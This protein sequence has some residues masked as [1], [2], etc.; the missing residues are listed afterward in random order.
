[1]TRIKNISPQHQQLLINVFLILLILI[2]YVQVGT[3]DFIDYDDGLY[4]TENSHVRKGLTID[5]CIWAF[6]TTHE[7]NW[8]PLTWLSH[9]VDCEDTTIQIFCFILRI[10]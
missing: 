9:M 6:T 3:F 5:G 7:A 4:V 10:P 1:M 2:V 8:H